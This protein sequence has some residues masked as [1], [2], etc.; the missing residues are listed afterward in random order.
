LSLFYFFK[1]FFV[2][3]LPFVVE[4]YFRKVAALC[5]DPFP[6]YREKAEIRDESIKNINQPYNSEVVVAYEKT[7]ILAEGLGFPEGPRWH[8]DRLWFSDFRTRKVMTLD[9]EG[10]LATV[11]EVNGQPSGL[12]WF[13]D[14]S[15]AI[16]SMVDRKLLRFH[17]KQ[18][19]TYTDLMGF[20][21]FHCN[22][23]VVD[24]NGRAY[25]GNFGFALYEEPFKPAEI[26]LV[27]QEGEVR[28]VAKD[29]AFPNGS[30]ITPDGKTLIV[31]ETLAARLTAFRIEADGSLTNR[32][33]WAGFD[34]QGVLTAYERPKD[35]V[36]PDGICLDSEGAIW[37]ASPNSNHEVLRVLEG[38]MI[39]RR[40]RLENTPF[41]CMLGGPGRKT[42]FILTS[43]LTDFGEV[44]RIETLDVDVPGAGFP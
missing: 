34:D 18:L 26:V 23:M 33:V 21:S 20:A 3:F 43:S 8:E 40:I 14:G 17:N 7:K 12:G 32:R 9:M 4:V 10:H 22:D 37:V 42:L 27:S 2:I 30:V 25:I 29:M 35:R 39:S 6:D 13:P 41:A 24:Q 11:V 38:G 5:R 36:V 44:G 16:V 1:F 31:A 19:K 28:I 15:L